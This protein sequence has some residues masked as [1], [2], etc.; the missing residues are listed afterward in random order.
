VKTLS[1][2]KFPKRFFP[3]QAQYFLGDMMSGVTGIKSSCIISMSLI[4]FDQQSEKTK[5]TSKRNWVVQQTS[6]PLIKWVPSLINLRE[7]FDLLS[8]KV[9]NNDPICKAKFTVSIFSN[10]KDGVL[11]AAQEAA[12]YLNT[13]QF[14][15]I[16]RY[17]LCCANF[18]VSSANV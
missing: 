16:P 18:P 15:M 5:F 7:G 3:G 14:K 4:F 10:S 9:D 11:R 1:A 2:R 13:Y 8:E 17:L 12:S 6:G